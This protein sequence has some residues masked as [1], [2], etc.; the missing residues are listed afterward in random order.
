VAE[1]VLCRR[2]S[3]GDSLHDVPRDL[4]PASA[5]DPRRPRVGVTG[6]VLHVFQSTDR[7]HL[8]RAAVP[9]QPLRLQS[10]SRRCWGWPGG[11]GSALNRQEL[12]HAQ[13]QVRTG[14]PP[15]LK[16][17]SPPPS[18]PP[19]WDQLTQ[20][21]RQELARRVGQLLARPTVGRSAMTLNN[22]GSNQAGR[23][24]AHPPL[25][26][27]EDPALA[28]RPTGDC[29]HP[30]VHPAAGRRE[31]GVHRPPVRFGQPGD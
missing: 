7:L 20:S 5:V 31:P 17:T 26:F 1:G 10:P 22:A 19:L 9:P 27:P 29:L 12:H 4:T 28:S 6:Q 30:P 16:R 18:N 3:D 8:K 2:R 24:P 15:P 14:P 21:Q 11:A 25:H 23:R 13:A